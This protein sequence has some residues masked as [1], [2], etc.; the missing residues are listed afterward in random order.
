MPS[1]SAR[2]EAELGG[3]DTP[4]SEALGDSPH[5]LRGCPSCRPR[6]TRDR[7]DAREQAV[8]RQREAVAAACAQVTCRGGRDRH[9]NQLPAT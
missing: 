6:M 9:L 7:D 8:A 4:F 5:I 2:L 1:S 3:D